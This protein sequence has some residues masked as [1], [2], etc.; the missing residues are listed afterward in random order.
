MIL[1]SWYNQEGGRAENSDSV[2]PDSFGSQSSCLGVDSKT[3][4]AKYGLPHLL[5]L[6]LWRKL[7]LPGTHNVIAIPSKALVWES[8]GSAARF[9]GN[10]AVC[11]PGSV[12]VAESGCH[13]QA[14]H[15]V[16]ALV[17]TLG[18]TLPIMLPWRSHFHLWGKLSFSWS[19]MQRHSGPFSRF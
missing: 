9:L 17:S 10:K 16:V 12:C 15:G 2:E 14:G 1:R 18:W 4:A 8:P 5:P 13:G 6:F 3:L 19:Q 11:P 7:P